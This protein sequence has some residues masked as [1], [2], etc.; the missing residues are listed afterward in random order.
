MTYPPQ[1]PGPYGPQGPYGP[2]GRPGP[3]GQQPGGG[4]PGGGARQ[5]GYPQ[6]GQQYPGYPPS[7]QQPPYPQTPPPGSPGATPQFGQDPYATQQFPGGPG[8]GPPKKK[9]GLIVGLAIAA[10]LVLGGATVGAWFLFKDDGGSNT[11]APSTSAAAPPAPRGTAVPG[12]KSSPEEAA[13]AIAT[14]YS[15]G[16]REALQA[17]V[18][19]S[20]PQN[21][22]PIPAGVTVTVNGSPDV[23]GDSAYVPV[24]AVGPGGT[25]DFD[26]GLANEGGG[27]C[28]LGD[29]LNH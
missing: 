6:G 18:C 24:H 10:V 3:Y 17:I 23:S 25:N 29:R 5:P 28:Y 15:T 27:W 13:Q 11:A 1:P 21:V 26:L 16:D 4:Y 7:G 9:T 12:A 8:G 2:P 14:A 19:A 22:P 20:K